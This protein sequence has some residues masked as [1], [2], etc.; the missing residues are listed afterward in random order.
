MS[1]PL[2]NVY[3]CRICG[4]TMST[5]GIFENNLCAECLEEF[6]DEG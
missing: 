1:M 2:R 4:R 3:T 6:K 5:T